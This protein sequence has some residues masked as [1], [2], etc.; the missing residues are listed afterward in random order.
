M[1]LEEATVPWDGLAVVCLAGGGIGWPT[2]EVFARALSIAGWV[3]GGEAER[4]EA[5]VGRSTCPPG[6]ISPFS[7]RSSDSMRDRCWSEGS[8]RCV[9]D[10]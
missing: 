10:H 9:A 8:M 2:E 7:I 5:E 3:A 1:A 4:S 6:G